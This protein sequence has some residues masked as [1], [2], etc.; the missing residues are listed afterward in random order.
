[1]ANEY[2]LK[3]DGVEVT[4]YDNVVVNGV[5]YKLKKAEQYFYV[6]YGYADSTLRYQFLLPEDNISFRNLL[7]N[8][9]SIDQNLNYTYY[10]D[11]NNNNSAYYFYCSTSQLNSSS[12]S[13]L[14]FHNGSGGLSISNVNLDTIITK[15]SVFNVYWYGGGSN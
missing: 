3:I 2:T 6:D 13:G 14:L 10:Y 15:N 4:D 12:T 9:G 7:I 8:Y 11:V 1:M 5:S